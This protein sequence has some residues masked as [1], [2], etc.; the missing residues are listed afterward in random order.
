[1]KQLI[2][3]QSCN[4]TANVELEPSVLT[5]YVQLLPAA[6]TEPV[7]IEVELD[8]QDTPYYPPAMPALKR[9]SIPRKSPGAIR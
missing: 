7:P 1:M 5:E 2:F 6:A 9:L 8:D 3:N 4:F